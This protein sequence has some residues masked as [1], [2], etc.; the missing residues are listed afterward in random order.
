MSVRHLQNPHLFEGP[1]SHVCVALGP[2]DVERWSQLF[3]DI[4]LPESLSKAVPKRKAEFVAGRHCA[5]LALTRAAEGR[6]GPFAPPPIGSERAP[7]WPGGFVGSITHTHGY[8]A[9]AAARAEGVRSLGLDS[10]RLMS[11]ETAESVGSMVT[12]EGEIDELEGAD[13]LDSLQRLTLIFSAKETLYK[14][15][16]PLVGRFFGFHEA[17]LRSF[18]APAGRYVIELTKG[19]TAEFG[20][21]AR[22]GGR[23]ALGDG[24]V[25]TGMELAAGGGAVGSSAAREGAGR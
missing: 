4:A 8:V 3:A 11:A 10:E 25:H 5:R 2:G 22:F 24:L 19:L 15:L 1:V 7:V 16:H 21:G 18:D 23:F 9:A 20:P 12:I 17:R 6:G 14:C 13:G